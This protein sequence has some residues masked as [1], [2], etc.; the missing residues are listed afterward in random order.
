M[1]RDEVPL[2]MQLEKRDMQTGLTVEPYYLEYLSHFYSMDRGKR[3]IRLL[4]PEICVFEKGLP[5]Y[6]LT[7]RKVTAN[8]SLGK[9]T[10]ANDQE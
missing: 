5:V 7:K 4:L 2:D 1:V 8:H 10:T 9:P 3:R 6:M